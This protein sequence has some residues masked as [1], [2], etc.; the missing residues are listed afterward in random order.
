MKARSG[1]FFDLW[2]FF[3]GI[4]YGITDNISIAA[5]ASIIPEVDNQLYYIIPKVA[6]EATEL[7]DVG[8]SVMIFRLWDETLFFGLGS[9]TYGTDDASLTAGLG[10]AWNSEG[11]METPALQVGGEY[12]VA[13]RM[14]LVAETWSIPGEEDAGI[15]I[16]GG[17]RLLGEGMTIDLGFATSIEADEDQS[18]DAEYDDEDDDNDDGADWFPYID[19]VWNF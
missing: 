3:P 9:A 12:R 2:V 6:F 4:A 15:L 17:A 7:L 5:G 10:L 8:A 1:Y 14:A 19:F 18:L 16:L 11:M 13:R